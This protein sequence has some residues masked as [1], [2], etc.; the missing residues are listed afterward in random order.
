MGTRFKWL[1]VFLTATLPSVIYGQVSVAT[2]TGLVKD[3]QGMPIAGAHVEITN[4]NTGVLYPATT[5][6]AGLYVVPLLPPGIYSTKVTSQGFMRAEIANLPLRSGDRLEKDFQLQLGTVTQSVVVTSS[7][8]PLEMTASREQIVP[9]KAVED[10][11]LLGRN[12]VLLSLLTPGVKFPSTDTAN[13]TRPF[14]NGG[15][16]AMLINGGVMYRNNFT[17]NGLPDTA[18]ESA[19]NPGELSFVPPPDAVSEVSVATSSYDAQYGHSGGGTI[20][21]NLKSGTNAFHGAAYDYVRNTIF[22][23]NRWENNAKGVPRTPYHWNQP[24]VEID[25]PVYLPTF[26]NG[27]DKTFFMFSWERIQDSIPQPYLASVPTPAQRNGDFSSTT[28]NGVPIT[29]YD[30]LTTIQTAPGVYSRTPF[31][32]NIIPSNQI[33]PIAAKVLTYYPSPNTPGTIDHLNNYF[34][35]NS[36]VTDKYD[37]FSTRVDQ[38]INLK[39]RLWLS[40]FHS[41]RHQVEPTYNFPDPAASP[42]YLH[43]RLNRGGAV[44]WTATLNPTTVFDVSYGIEQHQFAI[45]FYNFGFNPEKLGYSPALVSQFAQ[46]TFP[47]FVATGYTSLG[48]NGSVFTYTTTQAVQATL[49]KVVARHTFKWGTQFNVVLNNYNSPT[50]S[51]GTFTFDPTFTQL[52]PLIVNPLQG[53]SFASEIL[54]YSTSGSVPING[55]FAY[56][57]HYY[58]LFMQDDWRVSQRLTL[59]LGL[60][61]DVETPLTERHNQLNAGFAFNQPSPLQVPGYNLTG[62]LLFVNGSHR[63]GFITDYNNVQPRIGIA[64]RLNNKTVVRGGFGVFY[65]PTFDIPGTQGF[66]VSTPYV[67]S[68]N[69]NATPANSLS[70]PYPGGILRPSGSSKGLATLLGTSISFADPSRVIPRNEQFSFGFER[71]FPYHI[72][73]DVSYVGARTHELEVSQNIDAVPLEDL[74][75]GTKL[76]T[77]VPNPFKGLLPG[78]NL[79]GPTITLQQSL[80]PY[81]QYTGITENDIPIGHNSYNALQV[82]VE[83]RFLSGLFLALNYTFSKNLQATSFLNPQDGTNPSKL[84][85]QLAP[86]DVPQNLNISGGYELPFF[87]NR[88]GILHQILSGWQI[89]TVFTY[90]S[91]TPVPAPTVVSGQPGVGVASTGINPAIPNPSRQAAFNTCYISLSGT[92]QDCSSPSQPAAWIQLPPFSLNTLTPLL[93]NIR[94]VRPPLDDVSVFKTFPIRERLNLQFRVESFNVA[95]TVWFPAPNTVLTSPLFGQTTLAPGGFASTA[96]D[97]R[98]FQLSAR[99]MF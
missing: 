14:D 93:P 8:A 52:S 38:A 22:N 28:F 53:N 3:P 67:A 84:A 42:L 96:N 47:Q 69:G 32:G 88:H 55:S 11:P 15:M 73:A 16:D 5:N 89:N 64:Y 65:L 57:S 23:A 27:H 66:S 62:G 24:G 86:Y 18:S 90:T 81:P 41:D 33:N 34:D 77:V 58:A 61:W 56:S 39:N 36:V 72:V 92:R 83:R 76:N 29:I 80:L 40:L 48:N 17:L 46:L 54:G 94:L 7:A 21:V 59:S 97:P 60:R 87:R 13:A 85:N 20:N 91:G 51:S 44:D 70:N 74:S 4:L 50:S 82:R 25:G 1:F 79:N 78:T 12:T 75:L 45:R 19:G 37:A 26:Y 9:E 2:I 35:G 10:L 43:W 31:P 30:P 68:N 99:L 63:S 49:T 95:N 6:G 71:E 98:V